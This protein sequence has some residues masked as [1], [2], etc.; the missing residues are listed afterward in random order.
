MAANCIWRA[1]PAPGTTV[2]VTPAARQHEY[3]VMN[4][5]FRPPPPASPAPTAKERRGVPA[6]PPVQIAHIVS[7]A[8]SHAIAVLEHR[9]QGTMITKDPRVQIG[10]LVKI[11]TPSSS[12]MGLVSA[13]TSPMP[14]LDGHQDIGLIEINLA[15]EVGIDDT[16][17]RLT[18][19][20]GVSSLPSIGDPV[21]FADRHDLTRVYA[22]PGVASVKVGSLFQDAT[23]P[24]RLLTDDLLA[25][26]FI[27]VGSTG[28]GKSCALTAILQRML[29]E[30]PAARMS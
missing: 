28:S 24:A 16:S 4:Q 22:P 27:V 17:R 26:H 9:V 30:H 11:V 6:T 7:V 18:F 2:F 3:R 5:V 20:R 23:V 25:K 10:A 13:V 21:L 15:G 1:S 29:Y 12:V 14:T 8:G 19:R